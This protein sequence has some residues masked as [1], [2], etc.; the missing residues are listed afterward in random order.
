MEIFKIA[1]VGLITATCLAVVR[2]AR[3]EAATVI[4]LAGGALILAMLVDYFTG[5]FAFFDELVNATGIDRGV[6][7]SLL[8]IVGVGYVTELAAGVCEDGGAKS[9]GDKIVLGGKLIIF[10]LTIPV[11][12]TLLGVIASLA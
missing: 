7:N 2:D 12:R 1:A 4:A 10:T 11:L 5:I 8:K 9:V 3:G 6:I